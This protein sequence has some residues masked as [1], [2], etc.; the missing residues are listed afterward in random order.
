[1]VLKAWPRRRGQALRLGVVD[2]A[3]DDGRRRE[4]RQ[5]PER[6]AQREQL[7]RIDAARGR[8]HMARAGHQVRDRVEAAPCDIGAA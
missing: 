8:H 3:L 4:G 5:R 6:M 2:Q 7:G 1:M